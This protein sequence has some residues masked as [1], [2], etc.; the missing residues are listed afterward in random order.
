M[1]KARAQRNPQRPYR[2]IT[3]QLKRLYAMQD[4]MYETVIGGIAEVSDKVKACQAWKELEL[5]RRLI[6]GKPGSIQAALPR[7]IQ[8]KQRAKTSEM[9]PGSLDLDKAA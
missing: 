1:L 3:N 4:V 6:Q 8:R 2:D 5:L 7:D 9:R